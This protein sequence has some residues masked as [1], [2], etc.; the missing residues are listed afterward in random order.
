[1]DFKKILPHLIAV[2]LFIVASVLY[3]S[4]V[5][6]GKKIKQSD[7]T[8][9]IGMSKQQNDFRETE[10]SEPYWTD[11]AYGGM[12]TYQLGAQYPH[13]YIKKLDKVLRFL[14]RPAD[15]VFLYFLCFYILL[16]VLKVD[17]RYA[18]LGSFAFGFST[19]YI[20][21]LGVGHNAKAH[22]IAYMPLV[23][24]GIFLVFRKK[25]IFG[26]LL[27]ALAMGLELNANHPQMTY[28]LLILIGVIGLVYLADA[29]KKK[30]LKHYFTSVGILTAGVILSLGL[31]ATNLM[32]TKE[33]ANESTRSKSELTID[34][35][36]AK[37][38]VSSGLD[39]EYITHWSYGI[40]ES[41]NLFVPRLFGG[42]TNEPLPKD[43]KVIKAMQN[44]FREKGY[45]VPRKTA[46]EYAG[47]MMY[48]ADQPGVS[49]PAYIGAVCIFLFV[50]GLFLV[51]GRLK[52]WVLIGGGLILMLSWGKNFS[53]LTNF[54]IDYVPLYNKF[55]AVSSMQVIVEMVIPILAIFGLYRFMNDYEQKDKKKK[56]LLYTTAITSGLLLLFLALSGS[57]F[58]FVGTRDG[59]LLEQFGVDFLNAVKE[60]RANLFTSDILRT[61]TFVLLTA[62]VLWLSMVDKLKENIALLIIGCLML[63]DLV[64]VDR[65]YVNDDAFVSAIQVNKPFK[66]TEADKQILKDKS[67]YR[68]LDRFEGARA[69]YFH[70]AFGGYHGAKPKRA[71]D[72]YEFYVAKNKIDVIN[73]LNIK[74]VIQEREG[75]TVALNNPYA[76][77]N[78]WFVNKVETVDNA[79]QEI[80]ALDR[81]KLNEQAVVQKNQASLQPTYELDSLAT[82]KLTSYKPNH[83]VYESNNSNNGVGVFSEMYYKNGWNASI[84]GKDVSHFKINYLL[85]GLEIPKGKHTIEFKFEPQVIKT[86]STITLASSILLMLLVLGGV[87]FELKR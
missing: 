47:S 75:K 71:Q 48:W 2:L 77:G 37:K 33:Y 64:G 21:I 62:A 14:P 73:M 32:A 24:A 83:L 80:L 86:G 8:Q 25:Y 5:L 12:P 65:R 34:A 19:Y 20:I 45:Q 10:K 7:I 60:E 63:F 41:F 67:H 17:W 15:Y 29:F 3:F 27:T 40:G 23:L 4:P 51:K 26:F 46:E 84:D 44:S 6:Q 55:R 35:L 78:A 59:M 31:N 79:D 66:A 13:N 30:K 85:R 11:A 1:M 82:I 68:V 61:L 36:G 69:S 18:L 81:L 9:Y 74:Y 16:L 28:Y 42:S 22:A 58:D 56:A 76:Y 53:F 54:F 43:A 70:K 72:I 52:R 49:A 57:V 50:L 87:Y 39:K 38:V